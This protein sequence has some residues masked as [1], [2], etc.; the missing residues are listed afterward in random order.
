MWHRSGSRVCHGGE[1]FPHELH[2]LPL[3]APVHFWAPVNS[4]S[5]VVRVLVRLSYK[6]RFYK[7]DGFLKAEATLQGSFCGS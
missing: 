4:Q 1:R 2:P 6:F 5:L 7:S 3:Q